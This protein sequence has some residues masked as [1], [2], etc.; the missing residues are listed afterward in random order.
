[1]Q[2]IIAP[3]SLDPV[4]SLESHSLSHPIAEVG[5]VAVVRMRKDLSRINFWSARLDFGS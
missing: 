3:I 4:L 2:M 1:M 5:R